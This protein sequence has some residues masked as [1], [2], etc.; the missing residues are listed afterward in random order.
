LASAA[1]ERALE[2]GFDFQ[3]L[4]ERYAPD[5]FPYFILRRRARITKI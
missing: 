2:T 1:T 4:Y 3:T 5:V